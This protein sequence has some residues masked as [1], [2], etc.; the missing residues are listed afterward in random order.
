MT[1]RQRMAEGE[2]VAKLFAVPAVELD[3]DK[4]WAYRVREGKVELFV[5]QGKFIYVRLEAL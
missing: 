1:I 2:A 4:A 5:Y 3:N